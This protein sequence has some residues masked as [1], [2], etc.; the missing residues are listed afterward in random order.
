MISKRRQVDTRRLDV[1]LDVPDELA[2]G[3]KM[4]LGI[5]L[6]SRRALPGP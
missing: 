6:T 5:K 3:E 4:P 1:D 2:V